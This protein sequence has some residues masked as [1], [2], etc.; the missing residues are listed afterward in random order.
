MNT[1]GT[2]RA[3]SL[4]SGGRGC[5]PRSPP[6]GKKSK[7]STGA[8]R[9]EENETCIQ[10]GAHT[11]LPPQ[12]SLFVGLSAVCL[13]PQQT[14]RASDLPHTTGWSGYLTGAL[15]QRD[16]YTK[17]PWLH[18]QDTGGCTARV[19]CTHPEAK[20]SSNNNSTSRPRSPRPP[21][22][23]QTSDNQVNLLPTSCESSRPVVRVSRLGKRSRRG[24]WA[25]KQNF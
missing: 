15:Q 6:A 12:R 21:D 16:Q 17:T 14:R 19:R 8:G 5:I 13:P 3:N 9:K 2:C 24:L 7:T 25:K 1:E 18:G 11:C 20:A 4:G 10:R 23:P 22:T